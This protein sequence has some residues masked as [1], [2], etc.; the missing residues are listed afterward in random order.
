MNGWTLER[1]QRQAEAIRSWS[2]WEQST[3]PKSHEGKARSSR[4]A[5]RGGHRQQLRDLARM[6]NGEIRA[7]RE[8]LAH[9]P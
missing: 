8:T 5:W 4:N 2:P 1:R 6:V 7:A 3:G 9:L